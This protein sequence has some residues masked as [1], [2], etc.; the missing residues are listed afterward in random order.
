M[1][2]RCVQSPDDDAGAS[3]SSSLR[4]LQPSPLSPGRHTNDE[5]LWGTQ[6]VFT[7]KPGTK[8]VTAKPDA[9]VE[10]G[11]GASDM[12]A[13]VDKL[14]ELT[15]GDVDMGGGA[16]ATGAAEEAEAEQEEQEG[17]DEGKEEEEM[18][19]EGEEGEEGGDDEEEVIA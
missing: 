4:V 6:G 16:A 13:E 12:A 8:P 5:W 17:I 3:P 2:S 11:C 10:E 15:Q 7:E 18:E 14:A 1:L 19:E 9:A